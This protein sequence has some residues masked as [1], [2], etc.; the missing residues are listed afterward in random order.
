ML[1]E[2]DSRSENIAIARLAVGAFAGT[3]GFTLA[4]V[5]EIKVAVSEAVTNCIV[6]AYRNGHGT[7]RIEG[8]I[9]GDE[10]Q[11]TVSDSG[12]GIPDVAAARTAAYSSEPD[13]M[14]LGFVFM[15]SFMDGLVVHSTVGVGTTVTMS[16]RCERQPAA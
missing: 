14:G 1:L 13:R 3:L 6:H 15:E 12:C 11:I 8:H 16:K 7:V 2:L 10:L 9:R 4:E 5:D